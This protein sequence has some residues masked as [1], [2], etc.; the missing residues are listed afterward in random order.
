MEDYPMNNDELFDQMV[1]RMSAELK[2]LYGQVEQ[3]RVSPAAIEGLIRVP[4]E[5]LHW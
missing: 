3:G 1:Q 4:I 5:N 2:S